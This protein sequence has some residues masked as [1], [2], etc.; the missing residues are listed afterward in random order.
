MKI[1]APYVIEQ[2]NNL[3]ACSCIVLVFIEFLVL[4]RRS[5]NVLCWG[6]HFSAGFAETLRHSPFF[7]KG[8]SHLQI[9]FHLARWWWRGWT[10]QLINSSRF[11]FR[12]ESFIQGT[13]PVYL[14]W[15]VLWTESVVVRSSSWVVLKWAMC[16]LVPVTRRYYFIISIFCRF[17]FR[18]CCQNVEWI[19]RQV[20][21]VQDWWNN[22]ELPC[23]SLWHCRFFRTILDCR[24]LWLGRCNGWCWYHFS[25]IVAW[26]LCGIEDNRRFW[27]G[28][29]WVI[30]RLFNIKY[31]KT[32]WILWHIGG[33]F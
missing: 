25:G 4:S 1:Y 18:H 17:C 23:K 12:M 16:Q 9:S 22:W 31:V 29:T 33:H 32:S 3:L 7:S 13:G 20:L 26:H 19:E 10:G 8:H 30:G 21:I 11:A 15:L 5:W 28:Q 24:E 14:S 6:N 27:S 2:I